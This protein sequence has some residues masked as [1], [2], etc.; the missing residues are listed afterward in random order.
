MSDPPPPAHPAA[1]A[2]LVGPAVWRDA[3]G[4]S[5]A[6]AGIWSVGVVD[7][8]AGTPFLNR[9]DVAF[10]LIEDGDPLPAVSTLWWAAPNLP[11]VLCGADPNS[12]LAA[13][14]RN[15][16]ILVV[17]QQV[18]APA[19]LAALVDVVVGAGKSNANERPRA[20]AHA[21]ASLC[22]LAVDGD[23]NLADGVAIVAGLFRADVVSILLTDGQGVLRTVANT[24]L[25]DI[26]GTP[27]PAG[28]LGELVLKSGTARLLIGRAH[29]ALGVTPSSR[30]DITASMLAPIRGGGPTV[31]GVLTIGSQHPRAVFTPEDLEV[32]ASIATLIGELLARSEAD[33][34]ARALQDRLSA[35]ERLTTLGELAAGV[36]HDVANPLGAVR[37]NLEMLIG[38]LSELR[39][40]LDN[41]EADNA[42]LHFVLEDLPSLLCETYEGVL[43]ANDVIRQMKQVVRL[44]STGQGEAVDVAAAVESAVRMLRS[45]VQTR[46]K[47]VAE[48]RCR[49]RGVPVDL[50]QVLTN[51][52]AN[53]N[54]ACGER[55]RS[56]DQSYRPEITVTLRHEGEESVIRVRDNGAGM[57]EEVL[58]RMWEQL[59]TTKPAGKG[60]GLGM[61]IVRRIVAEHGAT[62]D[63]SSSR[64]VGTEFRLAFPRHPDIEE[65][66][67]HLI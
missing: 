5:L 25:A 6:D 33:R 64:G 35:A 29:D 10:F 63:V 26:V 38:H 30:T 48:N 12:G 56:E 47:L 4:R 34:E 59:F 15:A 27:C 32:C 28:G 54:D 65:Q 16:G 2:L 20:L 14:A 31:R 60:T 23:G 19:R 53:A 49:I 11:A 66:P 52:I 62:I 8:T 18:P 40:L 21:M 61:S 58:R 42:N 17:M 39:P 13:A 36:V 43:R 50:L 57:S 44:G 67:A 24:G 51:L 3:L 22:D 45:R 55:R 7:V 9:V 1:R 41:L 46:V 37:A